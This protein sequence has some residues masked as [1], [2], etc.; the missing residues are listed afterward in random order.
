MGEVF[1]WGAITKLRTQSPDHMTLCG[2]SNE[3]WKQDMYVYDCVCIIGNYWNVM[4]YEQRYPEV[5][6][7]GNPYGDKASSTF[8]WD[9]VQ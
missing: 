2:N 1:K 5:C 6:L 9:D 7:L 3:I 8:S 4:G